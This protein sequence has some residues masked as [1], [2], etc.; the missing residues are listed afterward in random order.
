MDARSTLINITTITDFDSYVYKV[1]IYKTKD[2]DEIECINING[3]SF[4]IPS[5]KCDK[6]YKIS[7]IDRTYEKNSKYLEKKFFIK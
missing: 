5:N 4:C 7:E 1:G 6:I 2:N 3:I